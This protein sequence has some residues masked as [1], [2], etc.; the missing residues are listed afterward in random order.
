MI[1]RPI[2]NKEERLWNTKTLQDYIDSNSA[3][4][5]EVGS[6]DVVREQALVGY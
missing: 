4:L 3:N 5:P 1:C 6:G 2:P